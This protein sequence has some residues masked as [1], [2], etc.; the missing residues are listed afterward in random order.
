MLTWRLIG[1]GA[2]GW[3]QGVV[4]FRRHAASAKI[5]PA[6][7]WRHSNACE[8]PLVSR[9]VSFFVAHMPL[10]STSSYEVGRKDGT[11]TAM[12]SSPATSAKS[13]G[14]HVY[15]GSSCTISP[16]ASRE[17]A[18]LELLIRRCHEPDDVGPTSPQRRRDRVRPLVR[19]GRRAPHDVPGE[20]HCVDGWTLGWQ[21]FGAATAGTPT[22]T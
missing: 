8:P 14:L 10:M 20:R 12:T 17:A 3:Y 7:R 18:E 15:S 9:Q 5:V 1:S 6:G 11:G 13:A 22:P 2:A 16:W 21:R 19:V 4:K